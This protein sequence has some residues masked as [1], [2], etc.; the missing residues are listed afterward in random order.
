MPTSQSP[1]PEDDIACYLRR[2]RDGDAQAFHELLPRVCEQLR[3]L[4]RGRLRGERPDHTLDATALVHEAYLRLAAAGPVEWQDR[5]HFF[6]V[7]SRAMRRV[8]VDHAKE[9]SAQKRG[10]ERARVTFDPE[11]LVGLL[12][13]RGG[14]ADPD[15]LL[16]LDDGLARLAMEHPRQAQAI[17][18]RYFGGLAL[19]ETGLALGISAPTALRDLRFAQAW[20][21][22]FLTDGPVGD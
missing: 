9:R 3:G 7:A 4:A 2:W 8:L 21:A 15:A 18:L 13:S 1:G 17:E 19:G 12:A 5:M 16:A 11:R 10:G 20:L 22:R 6:A 14:D